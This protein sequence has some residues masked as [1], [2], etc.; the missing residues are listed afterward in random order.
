[1]ICYKNIILWKDWF[2]QNQ[3]CFKF[4]I[5]I[6]NNIRKGKNISEKYWRKYKI[7]KKKWDN[8]EEQKETLAN[9][10]WLLNAR[11]HVFHLI[12]GHATIASGARYKTSIGKGIRILTP[13]QMVQ[14]LPTALAQVKSGKRSEKLLNRICQIIY[15]LHWAK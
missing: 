1:M 11:E 8:S 14:R 6:K 15:S 5:K 2:R 13:K 7:I 10:N 4:F 9:V 3:R 12:N